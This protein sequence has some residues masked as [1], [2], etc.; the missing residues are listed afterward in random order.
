[1]ASVTANGI[2]IEYETFGAPGHPPLL[3]IMGLGGQL[4]HWDEEFCQRL[5]DRG[6][7]VIRFDNRD[8]GL[9]SKLDHLGHP[10]SAAAMARRL[11][12]E[13]V[14]APYLVSD[15]AAD[16]KGL[17]DALGLGAVHVVGASLGG[18]IAQTLAIEHPSRV[19]SLTSI[20]SSTGNSELPPATPEAV[21]ALLSPF[22]NTREEAM[23]RA[24]RIFRAIGSPGFPFD[25]PRV[26]DRAARAYDRAFHPAGVARQLVAALASGAR[27]ELLR[28]VK[29][30][31]LVIHG[32]DDPLVPVEAGI[33][34]A[35]AIPR[36]DLLVLAGMGHDFPRALWP[37][38]VDEIAGVTSRARPN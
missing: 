6:H 13:P 14:E 29:C 30:S 12:G 18:M 32:K 35:R 24:V 28:S 3:L 8:I 25:E 37:R 11:Q 16:C 4:I 17:L 20:M 31:A 15:M 23:D 10:D 9:S 1:M 26:R 19:L 22:P 38:I 27:T 21:A 2:Q 36:A 34:T 33:D 7:F 5:V